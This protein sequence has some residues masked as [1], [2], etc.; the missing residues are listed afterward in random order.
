M[1]HPNTPQSSASVSLE[2]SWN[3]YPYIQVILV[4]R[5]DQK[6]HCLID[7]Y[8]VGH[9]FS[10]CDPGPAMP[11]S[12]GNKK[13]ISLGPRLTTKSESLQ[14]GPVVSMFTTPP[15]DVKIMGTRLF[16]KLLLSIVSGSCLLFFRHEV[17][18]RSLSLILG[19]AYVFLMEGTVLFQRIAW[20]NTLKTVF[21]CHHKLFT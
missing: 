6:T 11:A 1:Q 3:I 16:S 8:S 10:K 9:C 21:G 14:V 12:P 4:M 20:K 18:V 17:L 5:K 7:L 15:A 19:P 13:C 2:W